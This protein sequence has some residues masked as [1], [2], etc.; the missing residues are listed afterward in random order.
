VG[1]AFAE[2]GQHL[3]FAGGEAELAGA[4]KQHY[5]DVTI[6]A[7]GHRAHETARARADPAQCRTKPRAGVQTALPNNHFKQLGVPKLAS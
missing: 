6:G 2:P 5:L 7:T 1:L 4:G 3:A